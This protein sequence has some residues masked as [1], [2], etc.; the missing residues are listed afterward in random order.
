MTATR[1]VSRNP[2]SL[3]RR[4]YKRNIG[5]PNDSSK[6][7]KA[8]P[9]VSG[10][11]KATGLSKNPSNCRK[12]RQPGCRRWTREQ[13]SG[14]SAFFILPVRREDTC[15]ISSERHTRKT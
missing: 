11:R 2:F 7:G 4:Q 5:Q 10:G 9:R 6:V 1:L 3:T 14:D 8:K 13:S 12:Q 15:E